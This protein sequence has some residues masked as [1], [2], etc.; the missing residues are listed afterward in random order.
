LIFES[1]VVFDH[2]PRHADVIGDLVHLIAKG[3]AY[4]NASTAEAVDG[5]IVGVVG[6]DLPFVF[7][8]LSGH[9]FLPATA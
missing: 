4:Q 6:S 8:D 9:P 5:G 7:A 1:H 3:K 2:L